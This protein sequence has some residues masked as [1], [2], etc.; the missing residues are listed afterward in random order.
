SPEPAAPSSGAIA[1]IGMACRFPGAADPA[2]F[3]RN[4]AA[5][6]DH[7]TEVPPQRWDVRARYAPD[8]RP[9]SS[10]SKW[11]GFIEDAAEFDPGWFGFDDRTASYLDPL[12]RKALEVGAEC[13]LDAG[14]T[15]DELRGRPVGVYVG[16]RSANYREYLRPLPREAIVG[17]NQNFIGAH[18]SHFFDLTGPNLVVDTACSSS[19]VGVHLASQSLLLGESE[20][21]LAGGVDLLLDEDPYLVLSEG[22]ALSPTGR[23]RTFDESADGFV[24]GEGAGM[25]LLKRLDA[26]Q[27][28]GD[29]VLAVLEASAVNND[30]RTMGYTTPNGRAQ[31]QLVD[32]ALRRGGIDPRGIGYVEAHG[33][34]TMIGDPIELQALTE[35]FRQHTTDRQFCGVGSV[36][37][38][39][40]HLLSAAGIAGLIKVVLG[41]RNRQLPPTLHCTR[42]NP[43]FG[44][45]E[46]PFYPVTE[47]TDAPE[48]ERAAVSSFGFGGTNAHVVLRR[49]AAQAQARQPLPAPEYRRKRFWFREQEP[50]HEEVSRARR[51]AKLELG[52][53]SGA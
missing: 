22:R 23:C 36:K 25:V 50:G 51:S 32:A 44:F 6:G 48:L 28:D 21:A 37:S 30:G 33:T 45:A 31:R 46:S 10:I 5:G 8:Y 11:G 18:L 41:L 43:R 7:V 16:S 42:P 53:L 40:G 3:W 9:G 52:F 4:L 12:V 2:T 13:F 19:L 26:A 20:L 15:V 24:P 1:V 34:G 47:L 27:R 29:R 17:L 38:N 14:Y 49:A 39:I 35:T